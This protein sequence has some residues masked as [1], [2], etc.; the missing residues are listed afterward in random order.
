MNKASKLA[1]FAEYVRWRRKRIEELR[2]KDSLTE[3]ERQSLMMLEAEELLHD[4]TVQIVMRYR[5]A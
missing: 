4:E 1:E 2:A 3:K 5:W